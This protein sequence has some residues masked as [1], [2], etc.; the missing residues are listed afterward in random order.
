VKLV[1][2]ALASRFISSLP[3]K[4][5]GDKAY[6]S[7]KLDAELLKKHR[8]EMIAPHPGQRQKLRTDES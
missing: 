6:D 1:E 2:S 7:D 5:I 4:L 3:E 8:I